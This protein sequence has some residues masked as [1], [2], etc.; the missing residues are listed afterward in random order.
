MSDVGQPVGYQFGAYCLLFP[1]GLEI[2]QVPFLTGL[3]DTVGQRN[4]PPLVIEGECLI[5]LLKEP[6][7][8][9]ERNDRGARPSFAMITMHSH[10]IMLVL[11]S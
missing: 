11:L 6:S 10:N 1:Q 2:P 3:T 5:K 9:Q 8:H 7:K 4:E